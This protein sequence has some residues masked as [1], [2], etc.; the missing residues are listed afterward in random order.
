[1]PLPLCTPSDLVPSPPTPGEGNSVSG[2]KPALV[3]LDGVHMGGQLELTFFVMINPGD[4][5]TVFGQLPHFTN[6]VRVRELLNF[7][8]TG[9]IYGLASCLALNSRNNLILRTYPF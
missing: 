7:W 6:I 5:L 4:L 2:W 1:M 3:F 8:P 9:R